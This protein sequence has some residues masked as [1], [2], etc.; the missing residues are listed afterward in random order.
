MNDL[1]NKP[2]LTKFQVFEAEM[3]F[4]KATVTIPFENA[5]M[6]F[7]EAMKVKP[8]SVSTLS[9]IASKFGGSVE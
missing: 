4:E 7:E 1:E 6:F 9:K 8:K 2:A 5:D 3:G